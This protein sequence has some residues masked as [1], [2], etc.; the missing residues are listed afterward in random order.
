[1][2]KKPVKLTQRSKTRSQPSKKS[3]VNQSP[4]KQAYELVAR[5]LFSA[6]KKAKDGGKINLGGLGFFQKKLSR[7]R[8]PLD[9]A[10]Y[11]YYRLNFKVSKELKKE[12][13]K[14]L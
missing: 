6:L 1:M 3:P 4:V 2:L 10:I 13:D 12:L 7:V 8:S 14:Q 5:D 11:R 9:G